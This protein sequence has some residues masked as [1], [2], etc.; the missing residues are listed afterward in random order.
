MFIVSI[1]CRYNS[2]ICEYLILVYMV[3][4]ACIYA[5]YMQ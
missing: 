3:Q 2:R 1:K 5:K 4:G